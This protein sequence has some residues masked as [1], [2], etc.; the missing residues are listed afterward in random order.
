[1]K[2]KYLVPALL[3]GAVSGGAIT[4][5]FGA[6][7]CKIYAMNPLTMQVLIDDCIALH[8]RPTPK[9]PAGSPMAVYRIDCMR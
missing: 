5:F 6:N 1:M 3:V 8:G 7:D 9:Y 4:L 2:N